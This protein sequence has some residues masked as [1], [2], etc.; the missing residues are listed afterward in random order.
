[1]KVTVDID[2]TPQEARSFF[3]LPDVEPLNKQLVEEMSKRM[4]ANME[5]MEPEALMRHWMSF[6]GQM[7]DQFL[8]LMR[9]ASGGASSRK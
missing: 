4:G 2:C 9:A 8:D 1:M 6:G 3:G 5:M 7:S